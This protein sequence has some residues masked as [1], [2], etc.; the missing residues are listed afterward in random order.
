[1][2]DYVY[3]IRSTFSNPDDI[4]TGNQSF[5]FFFEKKFF[6]IEGTYREIRWFQHNWHL[7]FYYSVLYVLAVYGGQ[8]L[9]K[10]RERFHLYHSL[11][12]WNVVLAIFSIVGTARFL[13]YFFRTLATK[14]FNHSVCVTDY[15][16]G[17]SGCWVIL[18]G[19]SKLVDLIDTAFVVLRKQRLIFLHWYHHA[20]TL[21]YTWYSINGVN[22]TGRW[23]IAMN[24]AVHSL[25]YS[26]YACR[27]MRMR[28]PK[29]VNIMITSLQIAQMIVG[30]WVNVHA[31][32]QKQ[33]GNR[34]DVS[35]N[36][37]FWSFFVYFTFFVLFFQFFRNAYMKKAA[38]HAAVE[39]SKAG[40]EL[41]KEN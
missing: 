19:M 18:F 14:G 10:T 17:V 22:S 16:F 5:V 11:I 37:I 27:A 34:C 21:I 23:F 3:N 15:E 40:K 24:F 29:W 2:N 38:S 12:A 25:M 7:S 35:Y 39:S 31:Y 30:I 4:Q 1:M 26:Y 13:P 33:E 36:N 20:T 28:I 32:F 41:S 6:D 8:K 9:M